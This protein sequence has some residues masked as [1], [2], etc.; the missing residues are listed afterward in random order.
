[1]VVAEKFGLIYVVTKLGV[2]YVYEIT[3]CEQLYKVKIATSP[4]FAVAKNYMNDGL[5]AIT[6]S[7]SLHVGLV[8]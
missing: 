5:L 3:S 1:L 7:G 6:K 2:V 4:I 8:E